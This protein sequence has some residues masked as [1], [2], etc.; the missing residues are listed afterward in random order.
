[1]MHHRP[2]S[3]GEGT[4]LVVISSP[5]FQ[6]AI[7]QFR[8]DTFMYDQAVDSYN[9]HLRNH[10]DS[11]NLQ[12]IPARVSIQ[13]HTAFKD[14]LRGNPVAI[15]TVIDDMIAQGYADSHLRRHPRVFPIHLEACEQLEMAR[16]QLITTLEQALYHLQLA[17]DVA[18]ESVD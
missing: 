13:D 8:E 9:Q 3:D 14:V 1:M 7:D 18:Q 10:R 6:S 4:D 16:T 17:R 2:P 5:R 15:K 11:R 12:D